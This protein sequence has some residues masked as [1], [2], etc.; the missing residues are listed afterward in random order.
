[1]L[2]NPLAIQEFVHQDEGTMLQTAF[3]IVSAPT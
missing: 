1:M 2:L 3:I